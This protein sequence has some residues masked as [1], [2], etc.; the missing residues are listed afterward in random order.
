MD[1]K[2]LILLAVLVTWGFALRVYDLS[3]HSYWMDESY[4][5]ISTK[6]IDKYGM[7]MFDSGTRY[8]R[9]LPYSL[10]L[11]V[12]GR[13]GYDEGIM[14]FPSVIFG[15]LLIV[16]V[17]FYSRRL[18]SGVTAG[19]A[20]G[21]AI[22]SCDSKAA[23]GDDANDYMALVPACLIA[24]SEYFIAWSR[25]ARHYS[26]FMLLF[27]VSLYFL[28]VFLDRPSKRNL[29]YLTLFSV[30]AIMTH[31]FA[32]V[33]LII[34][35]FSFAF[36]FRK[37]RRIKVSWPLVVLMAPALLYIA[38]AIVRDVMYLDMKM[39]YTGHYY[40]F[41]HE[42]YFV[43]L[44]L[45]I[46][47]VFLLRRNKS[48]LALLFGGIIAFFLHSLLVHLLAYRYMLYLTVFLFI[49]AAP[50]L[51]YVPR[52]FGDKRI[53][54]LVMAAVM[55]LAMSNNFIFAPQSEIW[56]ERDTPQPDMRGALGSIDP[57]RGDV[58][59]TVYTAL[60]ELY[61]RKP[62]YWL[63]FDFSRMGRTGD[64]LNE[65]GM[66]RYT[67]VT[68]ILDAG[69]F[70]DVTGTGHGFVIVDEMS[71]TR[72]DSGIIDELEKMNVVFEKDEGF[73]TKVWVYEFGG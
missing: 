67:N 66:E 23:A 4:S 65:D 26:L 5:V 71:K 56:L 10:V 16:V 31:Q 39:N 25:Q 73:W 2:V 37:V 24:F 60:S 1:K 13:F 54:A 55:G 38:R 30:L 43:F 53:Q 22:G 12:F 33:L 72:I 34:Y 9:H 70:I 7:P 69:Q 14:R 51:L 46:A 11:F 21:P 6:N 49:F 59:V 48:A 50:A 62:D 15:T 47:G 64:W 35:F 44:Y 41:F 17:F 61:L 42:Q 58:V 68:P 27:F 18:F 63:A 36:N 20:D 32:M 19:G 28:C 8:F 57:A 45:S 52:R 3:Y 40:G 29:L